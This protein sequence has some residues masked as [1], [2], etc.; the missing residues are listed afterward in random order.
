MSKDVRVPTCRGC[1]HFFVT[2]EPAFPYGCRVMGFKCR[3]YPYYEVVAVTGTP[4]E[5]FQTRGELAKRR[6]P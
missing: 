5:A 4:C 3:R 6:R 1:I 2:F